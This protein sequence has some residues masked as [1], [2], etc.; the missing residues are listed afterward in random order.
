MDLYKKELAAKKEQK[1]REM[2][3]DERK[4]KEELAEQ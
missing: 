2:E 4:L 3:E 1:L